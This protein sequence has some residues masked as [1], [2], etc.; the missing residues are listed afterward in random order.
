MPTHIIS[1]V[2]DN[3]TDAEDAISQLVAA[4]INRS[5]LKML[6]ET[7]NSS[8]ATTA[9]DEKKDEKG[10]WE[11]LGDFFMPQ[12]DRYSYAEAM[13]RG[14][15]VVNATIED[16]HSKIV[17]NILEE[18]GT[19]NIDEREKSWREDGWT[20]YQ[21]GEIANDVQ[22]NHGEQNVIPIIEEKL[23][24]GKRQVNSGRVK[25]RSY[26]VETPVTEEINLRN[27][28]VEV[29]RRIVDR[30]VNAD[31]DFRERVIDAQSTRE[32]AVISKTA[33]VTGEVV[34]NTKTEDHVETV[35]EKVRRTEV[36]VDDDDQAIKKSGTSRRS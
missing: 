22:R 8:T 27:K 9:Y 31:D 35:E 10:F 5:N 23:N 26:M 14:D 29:E 16:S 33:W 36:E 2:F 20:G 34:V 11:S 21:S 30:P 28:T 19:V 4:G 6:P 7:E 25:V 1:A 3:R 13:N 32:E 12:A 18:N 15:T 24:I 17:E